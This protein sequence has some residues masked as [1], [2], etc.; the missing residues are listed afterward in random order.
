M[1]KPKVNR[2][3]T[4]KEG[5]TDYSIHGSAYMPQ[6]STAKVDILPAGIYM[7]GASPAGIY[8]NGI[9][10]M[11]D[12]LVDLPNHVS[13][14]VIKDV[15]KFWTKETRQKFDNKGLIYKRGV[16]LHGEPGTGKTCT[17]AK[18][19]NTVVQTGGI[20]L[21]EP[22][23][24]A[25]N[26]AARQLR[27]IQGDVP[28]LVVY[29]EFEEKL[30]H[31]SDYLSLLD[32]ELQIDNVVFLATTNYITRIP[33]RIRNRPSRFARVIEVG[34]P[35]ASTR[36]H[37]LNEKLKDDPDHYKDVPEWTK[38]TDGFSIDHLKDLVVSVTCLDVPFKEA[39]DR[40]KELKSNAKDEDDEEENDIHRGVVKFQ[41][42]LLSAV[43]G[44]R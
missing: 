41:K 42:A 22:E 26:I 24:R 38:A 44:G 14:T 33:S 32:G 12:S 43:S 5:Y 30:D 36:E 17:I 9:S 29:E 16:L 39:V 18:I 10:A 2:M 31:N 34:Y 8:F 6:Q 13:D 11:T 3:N 23:P 7:V 1:S 4:I 37:F 35:D 25:L 19:M 40:I 15:S 20:V 27:E 21:F 28:I